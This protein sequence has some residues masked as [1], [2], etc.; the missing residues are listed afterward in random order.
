MVVSCGAIPAELVE[1]ELFGYEPGAFTG[2]KRAGNT[3]RFEDADGGTN[4]LDEVSELPAHAQAALLRLLQE[5]EVVRLGGSAPRP[6]NAR[7]VAATNKP[8]DAE[9]RAGRFRRDLYYRLSVLKIELPPLRA[10]GQDIELLATIFLAE[11]EGEV[12]RRGLSLAP[13]AAE[14]LRQY[15]WPG[16]VRELRNVLLRAAA[17]APGPVIRREDLL[18]DQDLV[19]GAPDRPQGAATCPRTAT[20]SLRDAVLRSER[21][22]VLAALAATGWVFSRAAAEL[23]VARP[24]F[25]RFMHRLGISRVDRP[26]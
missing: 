26:D 3:G 5:R 4:F 24:T 25:Y 19:S 10:R 23:G 11:A 20:G 13:G 18:F 14:A 9:A 6:V 12:G 22:R 2:A 21:E 7:L 17:T 16:N 8:L 1:A 15:G